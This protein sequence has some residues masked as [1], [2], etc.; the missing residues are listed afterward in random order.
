MNK[1]NRMYDRGITIAELLIV[2]AI[3]AVLVAIAIPLFSKQLERSRETTDISNIRS[4]VSELVHEYALDGKE[5]LG[6]VEAKQT[7]EGWIIKD[8]VIGSGELGK[9][10]F[11]MAQLGKTA[12][13]GGRY[14]YFFIHVFKEGGVDI[15][16]SSRPYN[17]FMDLAKNG[18]LM[19]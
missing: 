11:D 9:G 1:N 3:I 12:Y 13:V 16:A 10:S 5:H 14:K 6:F 7:Q 19:L 2:V 18:E 8:P 15:G 17:S 4:M